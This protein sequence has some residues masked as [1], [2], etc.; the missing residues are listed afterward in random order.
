MRLIMMGTG[1]FAVPT[2]EALLAAPDLNVL[3]L[4]T[5]PV[6]EPTGRRRDKQPPNPMREFGEARGL[7]IDAPPSINSPDSIARLIAYQ[8]DLFV[9]C[10]YGQILSNEALGT[11]R[12]G[13]INLHASLLPKY[14]GAA[15]INW[16]LYHGEA[17]TGVTVI[18]MTPRLDAGPCL[19]QESTA[20]GPRE[21]AVHLEQR[22]A[23][24]GAQAVI[25]A[26]D[27][28]R[29]HLAQ[30][31]AS[32][33][34]PGTVQDN[35]AAT[36]APRLTKHDGLIDWQRTA[37]QLHDQVRAFKPW[38]GCYTAW[39]R[40]KGPVRLLLEEVHVD[41][42]TGQFG[43]PGTVV[44]ANSEKLT[45]ACGEGTLRLDVIQPAG[46]RPLKFDEFLRGHPIEI[47]SC[48]PDASSPKSP[49]SPASD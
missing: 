36:R 15:P 3:A 41:Q 24:I 17:E 32:N 42:E 20:I 46:K 19:V 38:P 7:P 31:P 49:S 16:A 43:T 6:P 35:R 18:H 21:D 1:P 27:L 34:S 8:A 47:G 26:I 33:A 39:P 13:G 5:R 48:L 37:Q 25:H 14:R 9:V 11:A 23:Q 10:D 4:V 40:P 44:A 28:L 22:L 45:I 29:K 2:F 30:E 12:L